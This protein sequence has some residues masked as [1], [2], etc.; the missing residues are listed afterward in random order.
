MNELSTSKIISD[1]EKEL[2]DF[3]GVSPDVKQVNNSVQNSVSSGV[4]YS[5]G[6]DMKELGKF[7]LEGAVTVGVVYLAT[8]AVESC[9]NNAV[10]AK[11]NV[12][13]S[14]ELGLGTISGSFK[15]EPTKF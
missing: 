2:Y 11:Y 4:P 3:L 5:T 13:G 9:F 14:F 15:A 7:A 10:Q 8:K 12:E 6:W 1:S